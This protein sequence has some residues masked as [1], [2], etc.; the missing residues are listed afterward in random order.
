MK[1]GVSRQKKQHRTL[2][3]NNALHLFYN[4]LSDALNMAGLEMKVV[5]K[6]DTQIWWTPDSVKAYLWKPLMKAMFQK[7][8]TSELDKHEEITAI[9][10]QLMHIL[11][12]RNFLE[13]IPFPND[14]DKESVKSLLKADKINYPTEEFNEPTI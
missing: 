2:T 1:Y 9:H 8:H 5:L 10:E 7:E 3:Q 14:P 12:E 13:Y 6:G 11:G 4:Q